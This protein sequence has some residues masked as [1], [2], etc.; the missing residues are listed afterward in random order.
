MI[1]C[2]LYHNG[3]HWVAHNDFFSVSGKE[4]ED[5]DR[6]LEK[7]LQDSSRFRGQGKQKVFMSFENGTIP[8]WIHQY[9][10]HYFN[11]IAVVNT[12]KRQV[13]EA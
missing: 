4:L 2:L 11:R 8:R 5:L 7:F 13:E 10:P 1:E 9:M 12:D 6:N 3:T